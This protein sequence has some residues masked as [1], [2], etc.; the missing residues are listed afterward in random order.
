MGLK[1]GIII[2]IVITFMLCAGVPVHA[3]DKYQSVENLVEQYPDTRNQGIYGSCWAFGTVACAEFDMITE[4]L[5]TKEKADFSELHLAYFTYAAN[6]D[7]L[8]F[9]NGDQSFFSTSGLAKY[10]NGGAIPRQPATRLA[11]WSGLTFEEAAPYEKAKETLGVG[12]NPLLEYSNDAARLKNYY[13]LNPR[14]Q[15]DEVK[16]AI[17]EHGAVGT[18]Y[19]DASG[20]YSEEYNSYYYPK[21]MISNHFVA[22]VGWDDHFP[23]EHFAG[24]EKPEHDGAWLIRNS[25]S[26]KTG[27]KKGSYFYLS[28]ED[29]SLNGA[30]VFDFMLPEQYQ[31]NYQHDGGYETVGAEGTK[32]ANVFTAQNAGKQSSER[33]D[34]VM[35]S[36]LHEPQ[37]NYTIEIYTD[38]QDLDNPESGCLNTAATTT[39]KTSHAGIY[40]IPLKTPVMLAPGETFAVVVSS[41]EKSIRF[42]REQGGDDDRNLNGQYGLFVQSMV[43][44]DKGESFL[45]QNHRWIDCAILEETDSWQPCGNLRIKAFVND[46]NKEKHRIT[47]VMGD[48]EE[49]IRNPNP[50]G[51]TDDGENISLAKPTCG[52]RHFLGWYA[53]ENLTI[54]VTEIDVALQKN[55]TVYAKWE[56]H[57]YQ[58]AETKE[59]TCTEEGYNRYRC[60]CGAE[61]EETLLPLKH[62]YQERVQ[63]ATANA[64]GF[65]VQA[66][67]H[68]NRELKETKHTIFAVDSCKLSYTECVYSGK[69][70]RP[71]VVVTDRTGNVLEED[72]QYQ[73]V[74][75]DNVLPGQGKVCI[76]FESRFYEMGDM[77]MQFL[78]LP[79]APSSLT[80]DLYKNYDDIRCTWKKSTGADGYK[81]YYKVSGKKSYT[82]W[83]TTKETTVTKKNLLDGKKYIVRIVPYILVDGKQAL[84][85]KYMEKSVYTL[86]KMEKPTI[87]RGNKGKIVVQWKNISGESG[88]EISKAKTKYGTANRIKIATT[89]GTSASLSV[90]K[91]KTYW[92]KIR[93]Y[94]RVGK[95]YIY[96]PWSDSRRYVR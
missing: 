94:K 11:Q 84:S 53:D 8:G 77:T 74:Y 43:N 51:Y 86:K 4:G 58:Y 65:L 71:A 47:Y 42:D 96:G 38:L 17:I 59:A 3:M 72:Y 32:A 27:A 9:L 1:R 60:Q 64:D 89:K 55:Q 7:P 26:N 93:A 22:I 67:V 49:P 29:K 70:R 28:Y 14:T 39:G 62:R 24:S 56:I 79:K 5:M 16:Q 37:V 48:A 36:F 76:R 95:I 69:A 41:K 73:V 82:S 81:V 6:L 78:I 57:D 19:C 85:P 90:S 92:Y 2:T 46:S 20:C 63:K 87:K 50:S 35:V 13:E 68:C 25:Q 88:Y 61:K 40:T 80:M 31:Y 23:A 45:Y 21:T 54:P 12:L 10:L 18:A 33:L 44:C 83:G 75:Q 34:A 91:G 30:Y 66:C 52:D 15:Q